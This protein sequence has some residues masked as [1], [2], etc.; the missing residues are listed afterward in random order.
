MNKYK[1]ISRDRWIFNKRVKEVPREELE[2]SHYKLQNISQLLLVCFTVTLIILFIFAYSTAI[3][4]DIIKDM[5]RAVGNELCYEK[6]GEGYINIEHYSNDKTV[7]L[8]ESHFYTIG[9]AE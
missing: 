4:N 9:G 3:S 7:L 6:F 5:S 8:C 2:N 1:W